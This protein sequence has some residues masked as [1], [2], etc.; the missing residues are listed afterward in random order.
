MYGNL[1]LARSYYCSIPG[2]LR[3]A[4]EVG[5]RRDDVQYF[6]GFCFHASH[7]IGTLPVSVC[8]QWEF[9]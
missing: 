1:I 5:R 3:E 6:S 4:A 8:A 7:Y 9:Y 2:E